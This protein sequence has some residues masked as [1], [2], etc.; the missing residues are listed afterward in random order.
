M[1][2]SMSSAFYNEN[3]SS[4]CPFR[5]AGVKS[6]QDASLESARSF[7]PILSQLQCVTEVDNLA[8]TVLR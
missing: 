2:M 6:L 5:L 4:A 7:Y 3:I 8:N 1:S